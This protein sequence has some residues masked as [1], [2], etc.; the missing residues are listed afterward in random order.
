MNVVAGAAVLGVGEKVPK[1][2]NGRVSDQHTFL[3][4]GHCMLEVSLLMLLSIM[5]VS[6]MVSRELAPPP[7]KKNFPFSRYLFQL[8]IVAT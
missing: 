2:A 1:L 5:A 7:S 6:K 8:L 3:E 4:W